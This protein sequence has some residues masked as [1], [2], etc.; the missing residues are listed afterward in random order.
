MTWQFAQ[1]VLI[2]FGTLFLLR[3]LA[4]LAVRVGLVDYP[5]RRKRHR[6]EIPLIGGPAI[7]AGFGFGVLLTANSLLSY[8]ALFAALAILLIAG[9]LDDLR[10][11]SPR[12]KLFAQLLA[13]LCMVYLGH[14]TVL[15]LGDLFGIGAIS[16][17]YWAVPFTL[18]AL[19]GLINAINMVDGADGLASGLALIALLFLAVSAVLTDRGATALVLFTIVA[20]VLAF[21]MM[22]M[23]FPWQPHA[24]VFLGDSGSMILGALLTW[25]SIEVARG[26]VGIYPIAAVWFLALPLLDMG[27]VIIRRLGRGHSPFR[28]GRDHFHHMLIAAG[29]SPGAAVVLVLL[30]ALLLAASGF[31]AWRLGVPEPWFFYGFVGL[32]LLSLMLSRRWPAIARRLRRRR[33]WAT[34]AYSNKIAASRK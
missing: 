6:G 21:W 34:G 1:Y 4:R 7:F 12:Q 13:G 11:L 26:R 18:I 30:L 20:V 25:F 14:S 9:L 33:R 2:F 22:N 16:T 10:D 24:K 28:A 19:L 8:R 27:V 17:D 31:I 32:L 23:R 15:S 5:G 29:M 3:L